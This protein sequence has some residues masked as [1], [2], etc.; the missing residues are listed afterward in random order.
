MTNEIVLKNLFLCNRDIYQNRSNNTSS[1]TK[2]GYTSYAPQSALFQAIFFR[3][4]F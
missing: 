4:T 2:N 1:L 3:F